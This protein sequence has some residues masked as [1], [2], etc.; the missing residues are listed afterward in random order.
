MIA[1]GAWRV[2]GGELPIADFWTLYAPGAFWWNGAL[3][4]AFG[5]ELLV[6]RAAHAVALLAF[7]LAVYGLVR[8]GGAGERVALAAWGL[9]SLWCAGFRTPYGYPV[10]PALALAAAALWLL[11]AA[12]HAGDRARAF[13]GG[14]LLGAAGVFRHEL[15]IAFGVAFSAWIAL[16]A[17]HQ[18]P[19]GLARRSLLRCWLRVCAGAAAV[20]LLGFGLL[21]AGGKLRRKTQPTK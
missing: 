14:A 4:A 13:A 10:V 18:N 19:A 21:Y 16:L 9:A 7:V 6:L 11:Q 8:K 12:V 2:A 17:W 1:V 5:V 20:L 3:F 15:G